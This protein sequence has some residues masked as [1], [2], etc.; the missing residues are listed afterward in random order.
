MF[1]AEV[2]RGEGCH[3]ALAGLVDD[4]HV[5]ASLARIEALIHSTQWHD[6][7]GHCAPSRSEQPP[8]LAKE[9]GDAFARTLANLA[10]GV[11]VAHQVLPRPQIAGTFTL[12]SPRLAFDNLR[13]QTPQFIVHRVKL[14]LER[15]Y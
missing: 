6:P 15:R 13:C 1:A 14:L 3:V 4:D 12:C 2:E 9:F 10:D 5:E 7:H 8:G 11:H